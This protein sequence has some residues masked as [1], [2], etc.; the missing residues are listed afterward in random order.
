M[1]ATE[2]ETT[3]TTLSGDELPPED[4]P[5]EPTTDTKHQD[6]NSIYPITSEFRVRA[7]FDDGGRH[8]F[9]V[10]ITIEIPFGVDTIPT[11]R[12]KAARED[13]NRKIDWE[14]PELGAL[15]TITFSEKDH[16]IKFYPE[17]E[18]DTK[19]VGEWVMEQFYYVLEQANASQFTEGGIPLTDVTDMQDIVHRNLPGEFITVEGECNKCGETVRAETYVSKDADQGFAWCDCG[20]GSSY[21]R[22]DEIASDD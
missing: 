10:G 7:S 15:G 18:R 8:P 6:E 22:V 14:N 2:Q 16:V 12:T 17:E 19:T 9:S 1:N 21:P 5:H 11:Q 3:G 4:D 13:I 20:I